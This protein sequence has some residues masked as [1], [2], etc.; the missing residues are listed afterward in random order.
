MPYDHGGPLSHPGARG[1][2]HHQQ[3]DQQQDEAA[4]SA[5]FDPAQAQTLYWRRVPVLVQRP[6]RD[7]R[8]E[9]LTFRVLAGYGRRHGGRGNVRVSIC[10]FLG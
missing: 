1:E 8:V 10:F 5:S 7:D 3:R 6:G 2:Q 4:A 9:S